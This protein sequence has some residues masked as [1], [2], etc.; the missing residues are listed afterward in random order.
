MAFIHRLSLPSYISE[1]TQLIAETS[2]RYEQIIMTEDS[3]ENMHL[4]AD[5][6]STELGLV[7]KSVIG[8]EKFSVHE[9]KSIQFISV[10]FDLVGRDRRR[11]YHHSG[12]M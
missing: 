9:R 5:S 11:D 10:W 3:V 8:G 6:I 4:V 1:H 12:W 7:G 2:T